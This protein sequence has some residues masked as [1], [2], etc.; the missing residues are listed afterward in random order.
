MK[1]TYITA[2]I[3]AI[4]SCPVSREL[5]LMSPF[6]AIVIMSV[7][8]LRVDGFEARIVGSVYLNSLH[9]G[10]HDRSRKSRSDKSGNMHGGR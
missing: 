5:D 9:V 3:G 8:L 6:A 7:T 1:M 10:F 4:D 2:D